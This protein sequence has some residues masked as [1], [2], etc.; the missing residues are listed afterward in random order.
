MKKV[1]FWNL[2]KDFILV[3]PALIRKNWLRCFVFSYCLPISYDFKFQF[4][5][6]N[7]QLLSLKSRSR[8]GT[9]ILREQNWASSLRKGKKI[10]LDK[11]TYN[12]SLDKRIIFWQWTVIRWTE[13]QNV[14]TYLEIHDIDK[15]KS[16][17]QEPIVQQGNSPCINQ[18][19]LAISSKKWSW[20]HR[21]GEL[22][23]WICNQI[24]IYGLFWSSN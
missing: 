23:I 6:E 22:I 8:T 11:N 21:S 1:T 10:L 17:F 15:Q 3:F 7:L 12:L 18:R 14:Q 5:N 19:L 13:P 16:P 20:R 2:Y 9:W 4:F 24:W